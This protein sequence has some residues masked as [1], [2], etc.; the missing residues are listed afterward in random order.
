[1]TPIDSTLDPP[2]GAQPEP[3]GLDSAAGPHDAALAEVE[4]EHI[5]VVDDST[6]D[7]TILA[8]RLA[9]HGYRVS[10]A[11]DGEAALVLAAA[12]PPDLVLLDVL[13]PGLDGIEVCRR[14]KAEPRTARVPVVMV[15]VLPAAEQWARA[16]AVGA[17]DFL[18]KPADPTELLLRVR[19]LLRLKR[20]TEALT[21]A[22]TVL[23]DLAVSIEAK[24]PYTTGHCARLAHHSVALGRR[25]GLS[26][27]D[28]TALHRAGIL[29]DLGK[30]GVP[31]EIL[32]QPRPLTD[33][34]RAIV[35]AHPAMGERLCAPLQS[36]APVLPIIRHHHE[37]WD[38]SG[39][40]DGLAGD[41]IPLAARILGV[42]DAYDA[43][44]TTRPF[45]SGYTPDEA[46]AILRTEAAQGWREPALVEQFIA[47]VQESSAS[48]P[49]AG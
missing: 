10:A 2:A 38:G 1:M 39:Y 47:L 48:G 18:T 46:F 29:H 14:L 11:P 20:H 6:L 44:T 34:E 8:D 25:L 13:M 7:R 41:A 15:T 21:Q 23:F 5:L 28:L 42:V 45:R 26:S 12:D 49:S 35:Q 17:E 27:T 33:A 4:G 30:I 37:R 36:L 22:A 3:G 31:D 16:L 43:L 32:L 9:A 40:P 19:W 24:D